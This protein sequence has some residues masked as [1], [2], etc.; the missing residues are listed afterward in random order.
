[1]PRY[2]VQLVYNG[3]GFHGWQKQPNAKSVQGELEQAMTTV[4]RQPIA[5]TGCGRTDTGVHADDYYAHFDFDGAFPKAFL[6]RMNKF[7]DSGIFLK[8]LFAVPDSAHARFDAGQRSYR[9]EIGFHR[10][11]F[12]K[13]T[14]TVYPFSK[15]IDTDLLHATAK[16]IASYTAFAP[17]CKTNSDAHTMNCRIDSAYWEVEEDKWT[18]HISADRFLRGMIRLI[19]GCCLRVGEGK[20]DLATVQQALDEQT[21]LPGSWSAPAEGLFLTNIIYPNRQDW[22]AIVD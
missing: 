4:L 9:Y 13:E 8:A 3:A 21:P 7:I 12:R 17:F 20:I 11:P 15:K 1:M 18:F 5:L 10:N 2:F 22:D 16:L 19:V 6:A 14:L